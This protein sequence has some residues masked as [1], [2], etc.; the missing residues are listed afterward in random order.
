MAEFLG[1][2]LTAEQLQ[3]VEHECSFQQM[4]ANPRTNRYDKHQAGIYDHNISP[5][6]RCGK[7]RFGI[8]NLEFGIWKSEISLKIP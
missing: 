6:L 8:W 1:K 7:L 5:F 3:S 2:D 4:K